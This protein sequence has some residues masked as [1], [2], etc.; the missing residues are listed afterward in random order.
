MFLYTVIPDRRDDY[1]LT[2]YTHQC[3]AE[4][5]LTLKCLAFV[6]DDC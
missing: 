6:E 2:T 1:T 5:G 3:L 4:L